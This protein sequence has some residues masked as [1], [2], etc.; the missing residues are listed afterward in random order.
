VVQQRRFSVFL[1]LALSIIVVAILDGGDG[2]QW[3]W[4][5]RYQATAMG[6][7]DQQRRLFLR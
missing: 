3:R 6:G 4:F 2:Q 7:D 1:L 5:L